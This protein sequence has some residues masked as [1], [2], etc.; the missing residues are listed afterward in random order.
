MAVVVDASLLVS[1]A[2]NDPRADAVS[3]DA[4]R[5]AGGR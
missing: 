3:G 2:A 5:V 4:H 1:L